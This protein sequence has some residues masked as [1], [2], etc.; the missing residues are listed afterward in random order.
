MGDEARGAPDLSA[1]QLGR[2]LVVTTASLAASVAAGFF[3]VPFLI[4]RLGVAGYGLVPLI[5]SLVG[6]LTVVNIALNSGVVRHISV[7]V[8]A[9]DEARAVRIF[10][11]SFWGSVALACGVL[12]VGAVAALSATSLIAV[13]KELQSD[14]RILFLTAAANVALVIVSAPLA[15]AIYHGNR[16]DKKGSIDFTSKLVYVVLVVAL[17]AFWSARPA[18]VGIALLVSSAVALVQTAVWWRRSM[19]WLVVQSGFDGAIL[20]EMLWFGGWSLAA[21][22][23][24]LVLLTVEL[25]TVNR[26]IGP[27]EAGI[28]AALLQ[29]SGMIRTLA[30]TAAT[31]FSQ[32]MVHVYARD[33]LDELFRYTIRAVRLVA[34][35]VLMPVV[36]IGGS[37]EPLL[38]LWLGKEVG[39]HWP[40]L[41][42]LVCHLAAN[43]AGTPFIRA[44]QTIVKVRLLGIATCLAGLFNVMLAVFLLKTTT[45]GMYAVAI[46]G[47]VALT[48]LAACFI[49]L[50]VAAE[51]RRSA[52]EVLIPLAV[53]MGIGLG[54]CVLGNLAAL[55][56][57]IQG[58]PLLALHAT[59]LVV[60]TGAIGAFCLLTT[61]ERAWL[62]ASVARYMS[63]ARRLNGRMPN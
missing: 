35:V 4:G 49:P 14:A 11:T 5:T 47:A 58:W 50:H 15:S 25:V 30:A 20:K 36:A 51:L 7:A 31:V 2:N 55:H 21:Y 19:P 62:V 63:R 46:S 39:A 32:P 59:G 6:Y 3:L 44:L 45:L 43:M 23:G 18:M 33:G 56:L 22:G 12:V 8:A 26:M 1:R 16:L 27:V 10:S 40:L 29:W 54:G 37:A 53:T 9:N 28:Y 41:V 17:I 52:R 38:R 57:S 34:V 61:E 24:N 60:L 42:V 13:P 48:S